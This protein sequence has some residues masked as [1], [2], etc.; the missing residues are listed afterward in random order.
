MRK[1][2]SKTR[3]GLRFASAAFVG[4]LTGAA[5]VATTNSVSFQDVASLTG[6]GTDKDNRW[7][8]RLV[9]V[10]T[11]S[12]FTKAQDRLES[13]SVGEVSQTIAVRT[14][15]GTHILDGKTGLPRTESQ[16]L[17]RILKG[18]R[19]ASIRPERFNASAARPV[20]MQAN[21]LLLKGGQPLDGGDAQTTSLIALAQTLHKYK[22]ASPASPATTAVATVKPMEQGIVRVA[23]SKGQLDN[24]RAAAKQMAAAAIKKIAPAKKPTIAPTKA[25]A[26][27]AVASADQVTTGSIVAAYAPQ[28]V[29]KQSPFDAVLRP[30]LPK[31][32]PE[33]ERVEIVLSAKDHR[34]ALN[35]LPK[36]AYSAAERRCLAVG[37]YFEARGEPVKGQQAVAQV[38]LNRVKN[39]AYPRSVCGVVYQNKRKRN[40]CQ[41]SFACDGIR[42]RIKSKHHWTIA[43]KVADDAI[44]GKVWLAK[45][46]SS[47][48]Y[49]ADYVR[50]RWRRSMKRLVKIG[51]HIFYRTYGGGWS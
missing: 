12:E 19:V 1:T 39:P 13:V 48:H 49:H 21:S 26:A 17:N 45:V 11:G 42:D 15:K 40:R 3:G 4:L 35:P 34:W 44:D 14:S 23:L 30:T 38:I 31:Q 51:R 43:K 10:P 32:R 2:E 29:E 5:I 20:M 16:S 9:A 33:S 27:S 37:V 41:F 28:E 7:L 47:S 8:T 24:A 18:D 25:V 6:F 22:K 36:K 46:A 50:P